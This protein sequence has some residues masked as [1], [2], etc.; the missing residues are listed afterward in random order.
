[1]KIENNL[2]PLINA[3]Q[4]K[5]ARGRKTSDQQDT[6]RDVKDSVDLAASG[7]SHSVNPVGSYEE[8]VKLARGMDFRRAVSAHEFSEGAAADL[9][10]LV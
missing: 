1:M 6:G 9:V 4:S 10:R 5:S 3:A 2:G 7:A 8:A